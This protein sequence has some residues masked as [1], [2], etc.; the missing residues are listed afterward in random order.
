[1]FSQMIVGEIQRRGGR[2]LE[3]NFGALDEVPQK[4]AT[5][6]VSQAFRSALGELSSRRRRRLGSTGEPREKALLIQAPLKAKAAESCSIPETA[7]GPPRDFSSLP[8]SGASVGG[9]QDPFPRTV[10]LSARDEEQLLLLSTRAATSDMEQEHH[11]LFRAIDLDQV[12]QPLDFESTGGSTEELSSAEM[13]AHPSAAA[14]TCTSAVLQPS[15]DSPDIS[16]ERRRPEVDNPQMRDEI[17]YIRL[18]EQDALCYRH[19]GAGTTSAAR[20][21][22]QPRTCHEVHTH[23]STASAG[24]QSQL[25]H[26]HL[27]A[28]NPQ[29]SSHKSAADNNRSMEGCG[30]M[31]DTANESRLV[32]PST[33]HP[34][35]FPSHAAPPFPP[36]YEATEGGALGVGTTVPPNPISEFICQ[37]ESVDSLRAL[38]KIDPEQLRQR[39]GNGYLPLHIAA[40]LSPLNVVKF[41][42]DQWPDALQESTKKGW[43]PLHVAAWKNPYRDVVEFLYEKWPNALQEKNNDGALPLHL[44]AAN[45]PSLE[46]LEF[47]YQKWPDALQ[48][49]T[50]GAGW[51]P[52]HYAASR[53]PHPFLKVVEFLYDK[54]PPALQENDATG[55]LPLHYAAQVS[56]MDVVRFLAEKRPQALHGQGVKICL[57]SAVASWPL[58]DI[59]EPHSNDVL[60]GRGCKYCAFHK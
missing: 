15:D 38:A 11:L 4:R 57:P 1:M 24:V 26:A 43:T 30:S 5:E 34:H 20:S 18:W 50:D 31:D 54:W 41:L 46:V 19:E 59:A 29:A 3:L 44:A 7:N 39:E 35:N 51:L 9:V 21:V 45:N 22:D 47:L 12:R 13:K 28:I 60:C 27:N 58:H 42:Y 52:L 14:A 32:R 40:S 17:D 37:G 36:W 49:K 56:S 23:D 8:R 48:V 6:K 16:S 10:T 53:N 55:R 33:V 2:F 25:R